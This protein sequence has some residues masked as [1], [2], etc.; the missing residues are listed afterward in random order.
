MNYPKEGAPVNLDD[1]LGSARP[2]SVSSS[3][4]LTPAQRA[5]QTVKVLRALTGAPA[6][7]RRERRAAA[8]AARRGEVR[9]G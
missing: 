6:P 9:P 3:P 2:G 7:T 8:R 4:A 5:I 1:S